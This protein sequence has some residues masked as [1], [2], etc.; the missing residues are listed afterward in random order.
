MK[1]NCWA[2]FCVALFAG[3]WLVIIG[4]MASQVES[5]HNASTIDV[6]YL[7]A[8]CG[9]GST[10]RIMGAEKYDETGIVTEDGN[11]WDWDGEVS[12]DDFLMAWI[13]DNSTP[14]DIHDDY[15]VKV[16]REI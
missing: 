11:I 9:D 10:V 14:N 6:S 7:E 8:W 2:L 3:A 15:I 13:S 5:P 4:A 12:E 1:K 16:W